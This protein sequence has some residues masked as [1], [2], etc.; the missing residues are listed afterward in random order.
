MDETKLTLLEL[1]NHLI[2]KH[3]ELCANIESIAA[4]AQGKGYN[5]TNMLEEINSLSEFMKQP[6]VLAIDIGGNIG[7]YTSCLRQKFS[8]LEVHTFEP[9]TKNIGA[10]NIRFGSDPKINI[11][12]SAVSSSNGTTTL[13]SD[14]VGSGMGSLTKRKLDH[15]NIS[16]E[17]K[18]KIQ[19]LRFE[20]YW[21]NNLDNRIIDLVKID[22]EGHELDVLR[23]FGKAITKTNLIQFEFGG[24]H[25]DTKTFFQDYWYFFKKN[26]FSLFRMTPH[27][28]LA[29]SQ[30]SESEECFLSMNYLAVNNIHSENS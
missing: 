11:I 26:N 25:I 17:V 6:P 28:N 20:D 16:F 27:G 15:F 18:E 13:F 4:M 14:F 5:S 1:V 22:V 12:P 24:T 3:P 19:T 7:D 29:I 10:L 21:N 30:Y 9:S 8:N 2:H 23:S